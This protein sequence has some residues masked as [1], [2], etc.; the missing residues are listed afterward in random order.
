MKAMDKPLQA[1]FRQASH[2]HDSCGSLLFFLQYLM[3]LSKPECYLFMGM[4]TLRTAWKADLRG[5]H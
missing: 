3:G 4:G 1:A 2:F 5:D